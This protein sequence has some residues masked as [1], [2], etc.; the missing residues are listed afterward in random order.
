MTAQTELERLKKEQAAYRQE[1]ERMEYES[2]KVQEVQK[3]NAQITPIL[4][5]LGLSD[6]DVHREGICAK[7][8]YLRAA[9]ESPTLQDAANFY[10]EDLKA[11]RQ[12]ELQTLSP[13][14]LL[15][16]YPEAAERIRKGNIARAAKR[17]KERVA[18]KPP[19]PSPTTPAGTLK[20]I[21]SSEFM[22]TIRGG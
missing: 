2:K 21:S 11:R 12:K 1:K 3:I 10:L 16:L 18:S 8:L 19:A 7:M 4:K 6:T 22:K 13:D 9:G 20:R 17:V 15:S 14:E 5:N